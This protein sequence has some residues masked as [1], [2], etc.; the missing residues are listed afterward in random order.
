MIRLVNTPAGSLTNDVRLE[1]SGGRHRLVLVLDADL[2][3]KWT[4]R[5]SGMDPQLHHS[6]IVSI[7]MLT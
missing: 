6:I 2:P 3:V 4:I 5:A 7:E 1:V